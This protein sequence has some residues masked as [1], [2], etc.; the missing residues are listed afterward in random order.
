M[1][2]DVQYTQKTFMYF[3]TGFFLDQCP[4]LRSEFSIPRVSF[5]YL[6]SLI[7]TLV[8]RMNDGYH[9]PGFALQVNMTG[10]VGSIQ[11]I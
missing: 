2:V 3:E 6:D 1:R 9:E 7:L 11:P 4:I 5:C 10:G 8:I